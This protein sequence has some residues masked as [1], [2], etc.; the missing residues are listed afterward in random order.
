[1]LNDGWAVLCQA[2]LWGWVASTTVLIVQAFPKRGA[3]DKKAAARWGLPVVSFFSLWI[4]GMVM[5]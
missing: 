4:V 5:A 1:M 3:I 2:G